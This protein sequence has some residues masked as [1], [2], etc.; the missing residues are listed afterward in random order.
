M[1]QNKKTF[2]Q[3]LEELEKV[4]KNLE[5]GSLGLE[6]S[7]DVFEEGVKLYKSCK[8][9]LDSLSKKVSKLTEQ[10]KEEELEE[11]NSQFESS[12]Q[13]FLMPNEAIRRK[14]YQYSRL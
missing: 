11:F 9:Q 6:K 7:L 3:N 2:E 12:T 4:V 14:L 8:G 13:F 10:L 5:S 1:T